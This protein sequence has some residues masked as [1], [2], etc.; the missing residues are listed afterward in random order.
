MPE[1]AAV[2]VEEWDAEVAH[3]SHLARGLVVRVERDHV[4]GD[5]NQATAVD[6]VLARRA[7]DRV[8]EVRDPLAAQPE[9]ERPHAARL[10]EVLGDPRPVRPEGPG[11]ALDQGLEEALP[12]M[13]G[14]AFHDHA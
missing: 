8:L 2:D 11:E 4:V 5:V 9:R 3:R 12:R 14:R 7:V 10:R 6:D 13:G 1:D